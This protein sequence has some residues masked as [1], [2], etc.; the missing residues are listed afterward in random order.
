MTSASLKNW[1]DRDNLTF[2]D[3]KQAYALTYNSNHCK[4][5]NNANPELISR[6]TFQK[7]EFSGRVVR[8]LACSSDGKWL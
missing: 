6:Y 1:I 2:Q 3:C 8:A 4:I 5:G 7:W